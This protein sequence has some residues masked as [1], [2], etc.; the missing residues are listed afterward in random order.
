MGFANYAPPCSTTATTTLGQFQCHYMARSQR[1]H[2]QKYLWSRMFYRSTAQPT[3]SRILHDKSIKSCGKPCTFTNY[4]GIL[5]Y[6]IIC[7]EIICLLVLFIQP[8]I[9]SPD[10][11]RPYIL[12][13]SFL[14]FLFLYCQLPSEVTEWNSTKLCHVLGV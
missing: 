10:S 6:C 14:F 7:C 2:Q 1:P 9:R 8:I 3:V 4:C 5:Q 13:L 12:P 11:W